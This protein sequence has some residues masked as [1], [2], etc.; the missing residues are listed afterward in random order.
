VCRAHRQH[1][2]AALLGRLQVIEVAAVEAMID[3]GS[4]G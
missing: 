4:R 1:L 3:R 2:D